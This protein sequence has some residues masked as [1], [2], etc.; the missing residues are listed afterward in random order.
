MSD[1]MREEFEAWISKES[2]SARL[3][4]CSVEDGYRYCIGQYVSTRV[5]SLW[6]GWKASRECLVIKLPE[7]KEIMPLT[8]DMC[9]REMRKVVDE[10]KYTRAIDLARRSIHAAGV[11]T[12]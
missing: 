3:N 7:T 9:V 1:L 12:K 11:K 5:Q 10:N 4:I 8:P 6:V 2:P